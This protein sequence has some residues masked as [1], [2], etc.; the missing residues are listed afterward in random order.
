MIYYGL[1]GLAVV[2][3][4]FQFLFNGIFE[5]EY[6]N[7]MRALL[8]FSAG[9]SATGLLALLVINGFKFEFTP[10]SLSIAVLAA[11]D[12]MGYSFFSLKSLG[13]INLSL[14][15]VF[16]MLGGMALPFLTGIVFY[17]EELTAIKLISFALIVLSLFLTVEKGGNKSGYKYYAGVFI[18]NGLSGVISTIFQKA[19]YEKI[20]EAGFSVLTVLVILVISLIFLPLTASRSKKLSLKA[21]VSMSVYGVISRVGNFFLLLAL[22]HIPASAQ[23]PFV[24]GGVMAVSTV[25]CCFTDNKPKKRELIAVAVSFAALVIL[26]IGTV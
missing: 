20:S 19:P 25:I 23:Y 24:T 16:A 14:Y 8:V 15:S 7:G 22:A 1:L 21:A 11:I 6:G 26:M 13:R 9:S 3:F 12:F 2:M 10:F 17:N 4:A 5:K 18:L